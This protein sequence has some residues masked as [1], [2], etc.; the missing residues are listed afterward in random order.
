VQ[1]L[2]NAL[3]N[4]DVGCLKNALANHDHVALILRLETKRQMDKTLAQTFDFVPLFSAPQPNAASS[5][6]AAPRL[7]AHEIAAYGDEEL[8]RYLEASGR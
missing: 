4:H 7:F 8:D 6:M 5:S 3:A 2:N 1:V